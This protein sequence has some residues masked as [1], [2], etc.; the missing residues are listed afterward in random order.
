MSMS[1]GGQLNQEK[2]SPNCFTLLQVRIVNN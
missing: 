1:N 2:Y